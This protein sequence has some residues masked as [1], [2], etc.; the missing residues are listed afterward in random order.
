MDLNKDLVEG[1][2][3]IVRTALIAA[4]PVVIDA[5]SSPLGVDWKAV[6]LAIVIAVLRGLDK[7]GHEA[8]NKSPLDL[9]GMDALSK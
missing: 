1:I 5:L 4:I 8:G 3:E 2:K 6:G 7:W 9:K